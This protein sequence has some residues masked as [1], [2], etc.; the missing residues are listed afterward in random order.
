MTGVTAE[1][2]LCDRQYVTTH[3][4]IGMRL[5][6]SGGVAVMLA[7]AVLEAWRLYKAR[8]T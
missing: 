5:G 6:I 2:D 7:K 3:F 4:D 1:R 8:Q